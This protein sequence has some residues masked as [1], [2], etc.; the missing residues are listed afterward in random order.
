[1]KDIVIY[2]MFAAKLKN[3]AVKNKM[4]KVVDKIKIICYNTYVNNKKYI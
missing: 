4:K 1:M 2:Q 3:R